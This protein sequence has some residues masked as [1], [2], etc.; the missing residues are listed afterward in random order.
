MLAARVRGPDRS[1]GPIAARDRVVYLLCGLVVGGSRWWASRNA[2]F[3]YISADEPAYLSMA[4]W[5]GGRGG[6]N[7]GEAAVYGPG[8]SMLIAPWEAMALAPDTV[9]RLAILTNVALGVVA[10]VLIER[11]VRR[12]TPMESP[13]SA[14]AALSGAMVASTVVLTGFAWSDSLAVVAFAATALTCVSLVDEPTGRRAAVA[15][16]TAVAAFAV[17]YR[18]AP[19]VIVV[20]VVLAVLV[21]A[22]RIGTR[23]AVG[24]S[25]IA[26]SGAASV[27]LLSQVIHSRLYE[28]GGAGGQTSSFL[29]RLTQP[30]DV[31]VS[32]A[33]QVWYLTV[34]TAGVATLGVVALAVGAVG[35]ARRPDPTTSSAVL[36]PRA[37]ER[38]VL[39][40]VLVT[41][42]A[43]AAFMAEGERGD[44]AIYGR[45]N[46]AFVGVLVALGV[47]RLIARRPT[48]WLLIEGA[49][50]IVLAVGCGA[51]VAASRA[52]QLRVPYNGLTIRSLL[53]L[54]D[55]GPTQLTRFTVVG[56]VLILTVVLAATAIRRRPGVVVCLVTALSLIGAARAIERTDGVRDN[57]PRA[58]A[59]LVDLVDDSDRVAFLVD[60]PVG[61]SGFFRYPFYAPQLRLYRTDEPVWRQGAPWVM[62]AGEQVPL[63]EAGYRPVWVDPVSGQRLWRAPG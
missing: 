53:A 34:T 63:L 24:A 62:A 38:V 61:R 11:L 29:A 1:A 35:G 23:T 60:P 54:G 7:L 2:T 42:L 20:L 43:S 27:Q 3:P 30:F 52:D 48:R 22:R 37:A 32:I 56:I 12:L 47:G 40:L 17:H 59:S 45:Y 10:F 46:D 31:I 18:F 21:R 57:D 13:W 19:L 51:L 9:Y 5:L 33:G 44:H 16:A 55:G 39:A 28:G 26:L 50:T 14:L 4:R 49:A 8:Y 36:A 41:F 6:W 58:A 15:S 25:V